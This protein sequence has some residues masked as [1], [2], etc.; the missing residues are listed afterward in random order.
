M[1]PDPRR[2]NSIQY[3]DLERGNASRSVRDEDAVD[4]AALDAWLRAHAPAEDLPPGPPVVRQFPGGASNLTYALRFGAGADARDLVLRRPPHGAR[5][6]SAHDMG[7][8]FDIQRSLRPAFGLVPRMVAHA[9]DS[10]VLGSDFYV[11][12]RVPG[13]ILRGDLEPDLA[14]AVT[15]ADLGGLCH[16]FVDVLG[17]LHD[18]DVVA[19]DLERFG[20]G[21]NSVARQVAGWTRRL[22]AARTPDVPDLAPTTA[23]LHDAQPADVGSCLVHNDYRFDNLVLSGGPGTDAPW[24]VVGVLDWELATVGDPLTELGSGLA[25]WVQADDEPAFRS[26]RR[27]PTHLDGMW[28]RQEVVQAYAAARGLAVDADTWRFYEVF[29]LFRLAVIAQQIW[30]RYVAGST[31]NA[32]FAGLGAMIEVL[33]RRCRTVVDDGPI[34]WVG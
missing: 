18:V 28:T 27:Q 3:D 31:T 29:G 11:M 1:V 21:G 30:A 12:E 20:R 22:E 34:G 7:R 33:A 23:W 8:E 15:P 10:S 26:A 6:G 4:V 9:G 13:T 2:E 32:A 5:G 25:Y 16:R 24:D 19:H 17:R 14:A